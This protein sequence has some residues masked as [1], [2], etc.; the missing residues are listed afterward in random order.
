MLL[1]PFPVVEPE[2][3]PQETRVLYVLAQTD[4]LPVGNYGLLECYCPDPDCD[5]RRVLLYVLE[6]RQP[7]RVLAT[8]SYAFDEGAE[9]AG[10]LLDPL[11]PQSEY[12]EVLLDRVERFVLTDANYV[13]RLERHYHMVK[14]AATDPDHPAYLKLQQIL[15]DD[16]EDF[17]SP[18][19]Q[20]DIV[21][22][23][24]PCPCGSGK[25]Y[26]H[27]CGKKQP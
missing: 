9:M 17:R 21:S 18:A 22:R 25:K 15:A 12:A 26:K 14:S 24:D 19:P 1:I 23:N 16:P 6:E 5:C 2:L 11:N 27:C 8:I 10:P 3:A 4:E 7:A 20:K 13:A